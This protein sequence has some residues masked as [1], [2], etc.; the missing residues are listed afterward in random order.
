MN[1]VRKDENKDNYEEQKAD[2]ITSESYDESNSVCCS[3][4]DNKIQ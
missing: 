4:K 1:G 3:S 2:S